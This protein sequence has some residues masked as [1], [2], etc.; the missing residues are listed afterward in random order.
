V[1]SV[2]CADSLFEAI[3]LHADGRLQQCKLEESAV[4]GGREY[5]KG[6]VIQF[7]RSGAVSSR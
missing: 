6:V 7:D 1:D 4:I 3:Y 5:R 2:T